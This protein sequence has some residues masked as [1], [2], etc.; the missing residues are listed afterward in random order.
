MSPSCI[1][2]LFTSER[3]SLVLETCTPIDNLIQSS[4]ESEN[5]DLRLEWNPCSQITNIKPTQMDN[6]YAIRTTTYETMMLLCLGNSEECTPTLVSEFAKIY[7]LPTHQYN[8]KVG[9]FRRYS[10][11]LEERN[12]LIKGFTKYE[13]K[14][15]MVAHPRFYHCY[16]LYG[17]CS[18]CQ[19][20]RCSP[21]W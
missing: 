21:V 16:Y 5:E 4:L 10:T 11:W 7:S 1:E 9:H 17:F 3:M 13:D 2:N 6:V 19:I 14:Y 15:Y 18:K 12:K 8:K 20:L